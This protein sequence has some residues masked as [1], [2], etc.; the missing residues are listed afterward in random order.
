MTALAAPA[1]SAP[2]A[3]PQ[4]FQFSLP[5][6]MQV[7]V[8]P[9]HRAPVV[10]QMLWFKVGGVDDP[11]GISGLAHFFEH[12]MFRG[13]KEM[14]GD[15]FSQTIAK[16]GGESNAFTTHD[17]TA[18]YEQI[19][20]DRLKLAMD[21]EADR[22]VNL[23]LSD[24][25]VAT[26][27]NV[28]LEERRMRVDNN[29]QALMGE[30][31]QAALHLSH[32]YGRPVIG[33]ADEVR[34]LDKVAA[35]DFYKH[36]YA[37]N[38]ATLVV[39]GDVT[40][41]QIRVMAQAAYGKVPARPL[42]PRADF[43]E[44]PRLTETRMTLVRKDVQVPVFQR[45]YRVPSYAQASQGQAESFETLAQVMGGDQT[46]ALYRILVEEK[47]LATDAGASYDGYARDAGEFSVYAVPRAGVP[48]ETLE[49]AV[50]QVMQNFARTPAGASDMTRAKTQLVASVTYRRDSQ[51]AMASAY[52]QA[53]MIGLTADDVEEWP[54]RI[55]AV[56]AAGVQ[57]AARRLIRRDA[58]SVYM[59]P[60][61]G[62]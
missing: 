40:P 24:A 26:E 36:H 28:V 57:A 22:M 15:L 41:E 21:L 61:G 43:S 17:Y 38:N 60:E 33:W 3:A 1:A 7:L 53:L 13:T 35:E 2:T 27:R 10:T 52:G 12:M 6:G 48:L 58:V 54:A 45:I 18:F 37:P 29:P 30:Q 5:N 42:Q 32:P 34:H 14:P 25:N 23:D 49:K 46:A 16:N 8:I 59:K 39:A 47:K 62:K 51:Y 4:T 50:D 31:M 20:A 11:P 44:P 56:N 55:R 19:A 9:D